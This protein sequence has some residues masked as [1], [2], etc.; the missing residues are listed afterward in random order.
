ML[1]VLAGLLE[2]SP[3][4]QLAASDLMLAALFG[5]GAIPARH[6]AGD[7]R[8]PEV[9]EPLTALP[10]PERTP[11]RARSWTPQLVVLA[12]IS[13]LTSINEGGAVQWSAQYTV[14]LG[15]GV[16]VGR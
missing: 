7:R 5:H 16:G 11:R 4:V 9:H 1:G 3:A 10:D 13:F 15:G 2:L 12:A 8:R 14:I 6:P